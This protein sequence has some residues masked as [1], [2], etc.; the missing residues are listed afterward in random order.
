MAGVSASRRWQRLVRKRLAAA[1]VLDRLDDS[2]QVRAE[3]FE[4]LDT[5]LVRRPDGTFR[6]PVPSEGRIRSISASG[7]IL[8]QR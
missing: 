6:A 7:P 3:L 1:A 4:L 5:W 8:M 2:E